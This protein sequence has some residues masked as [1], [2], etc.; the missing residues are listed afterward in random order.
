M[1]SPLSSNGP[2]T[3]IG[4]ALAPGRMGCR[5]MGLP[6]HSC[7]STTY[8]AVLEPARPCPRS[9]GP[10]TPPP[11]PPALPRRGP[12][13]APTP[14]AGS[15][16]QSLGRAVR[17]AQAATLAQA[18]CARLAEETDE[19][20]A[21]DARRALVLLPCDL[22]AYQ[23]SMLVFVVARANDHTD[24]FA[25]R[26]PTL[27]EPADVL[28]NAGFDPKLGTLSMA[29]KG[30]GIGDCGMMA[31]WG[32]TNGGFHLVSMARQDACGGAEPGD[33]PVTFRTAPGG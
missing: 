1:P 8:R 27:T 25:P 15:E 24:R 13:L 28:V 33:W 26:L 11:A 14:L 17:R 4:S 29:A 16:V 31:E 3:A 22:A 21:L 6:L 9:T 7:A 18:S 12:W 32:W 23:G 20:F 19:A 10:G 5:W 30:R 2:E